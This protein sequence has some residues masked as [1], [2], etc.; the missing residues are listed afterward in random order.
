MEIA[1]IGGGAAG[2]MA[3]CRLLDAG[4][5]VLLI[6]RN[7]RMG[8]K[9]AI[10]GKGRCNLTNNSDFK[11]VLENVPTNPKFLYSAL[12]SFPPSTIMSYF[13]GDLG[14][15]LKTERGNRVFP[16]SDKAGDVVNALSDRLKRGDCRILQG[17]AEKILKGED[18]AVCGVVV[19][20]KK[21]PVR[22]VI[23]ATGGAS[24]PLTGS[25]GSGYR[26]A[27][28]LGHRIVDPKPSLVPLE[29]YGHICK[30]LQG[31][32]LKNTALSLVNTENEKVVYT[33]FGEMLFTHFGLS[34]PMVLSASA[35]MK[36]VRPGKY[37]IELDL[38]P[39][40]TEEQLDKRLLADFSAN[41]NKDFANALSALLPAKMIPVIV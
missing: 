27:A 12:G 11:T 39:A 21:Y 4:Q 9:L 35:H 41:I 24:Y 15:A 16:V 13:E 19:G 6:E 1:I 2:L 18:G 14:L 33:D 30:A 28:A 17:K 31:L 23:V 8:R 20:G 7:D 37:Q 22:A 36:D 29:C 40:L 26:L 10:T 3:A 5:K 38:K 34:G 32:S 25:D